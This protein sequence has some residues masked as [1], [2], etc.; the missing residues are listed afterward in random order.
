MAS[1]QLGAWGLYR[2]MDPHQIRTRSPAGSQGRP[3]PC[4]QETDWLRCSAEKGVETLPQHPLDLAQEKCSMDLTRK[5]R[6]ILWN[7]YS[8]L[9]A[10]CPE[11]AE[12]YERRKTIVAEGYKTH[13][14][15]LY[16]HI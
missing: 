7:Q 5:E 1:C 10:L 15:S 13:Y 8:I 3:P 12:H 11:E 16:S 2:G 4:L 14:D 6:L 9:E